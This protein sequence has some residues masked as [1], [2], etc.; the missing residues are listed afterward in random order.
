MSDSATNLLQT[1]AKAFSLGDF[2]MLTPFLGEDVTAQFEEAGRIK[3]RKSVLDFWRR[4]FQTYAQ[5][6]LHVTKVA[7]EGG[8]VLAELFYRLTPGRGSTTSVRTISIFEIRDDVIISWV[9]HADLAEV[10]RK[11]RELWRRL[12]SARW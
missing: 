4:L 1:F 2:R 12:G 5:I 11:E 7:A 9:D 8:L 3:G 6:D 10:S